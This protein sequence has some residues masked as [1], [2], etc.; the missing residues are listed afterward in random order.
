MVYRGIPWSGKIRVLGLAQPDYTG[1]TMRA[2][3]TAILSANAHY[4]KSQ[5]EDY[6]IR[7]FCSL[8]F[9]GSFDHQ[10]G[11]ISLILGA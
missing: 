7:G 10:Y 6:P 5:D 1:A 8:S 9:K 3:G 4:R 2:G 11:V